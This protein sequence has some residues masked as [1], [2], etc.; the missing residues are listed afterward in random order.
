M[1]MNNLDI[2]KEIEISQQYTSMYK[3]MILNDFV[4]HMR[5]NY[6]LSYTYDR[7]NKLLHSLGFDRKRIAFEDES[8]T[9]QSKN[10][11]VNEDGINKN[12]PV[13]SKS[14]K[15]DQVIEIIIVRIL[16]FIKDNFFEI[17]YENGIYNFNLYYSEKGIILLYDNKSLKA[18]LKEIVD[19]F[20]YNIKDIPI[21]ASRIRKIS[22]ESFIRENSYNETSIR[23]ED[24]RFYKYV[25]QGESKNE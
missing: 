12:K 4:N 24:K 15:K 19:K 21:I 22:E 3:Y 5:L 8:G 17:S 14:K 7:A 23:V 18:V 20:S 6:E 16:Y 2:K 25:F 10:E 1:T 13:V 11:F 9:K